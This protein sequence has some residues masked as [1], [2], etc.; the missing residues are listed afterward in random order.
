MRSIAWMT[1]ACILAGCASA[2]APQ[3]SADIARCDALAGADWRRI[4]PPDVAAELLTLAHV[5]T[6]PALARWYVAADGAHAACL[7]PDAGATCG[8]ALHTFQPQVHR[9]W[10]WSDSTVRRETCSTG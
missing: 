3:A 1:A 9:M 10:G 2:P 6:A 5:T 4:E 7:P 8:H